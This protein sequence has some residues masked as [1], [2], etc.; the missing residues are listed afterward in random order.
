MI[1]FNWSLTKIKKDDNKIRKLL[2][3]HHMHHPKSD[4]NRL[5]LPCK[6]GGRGLAQVELS[7]KTLVIGMA[8]YLNINDWMLKLVKK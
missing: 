3:M 8:T 2:T 6:E 7:L 5:Y 1:H 4:V